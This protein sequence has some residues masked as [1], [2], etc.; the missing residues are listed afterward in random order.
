MEITDKK[1]FKVEDTTVKLQVIT[2]LNSVDDETEHF[3]VH[4]MDLTCHVSVSFNNKEDANAC[5]K[6]FLKMK[7]WED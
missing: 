4:L 6:T 2:G 7:N 5:F 3:F 1:I